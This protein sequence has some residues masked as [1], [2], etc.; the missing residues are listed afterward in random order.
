MTGLTGESL[1]L[2]S[3]SETLCI[4]PRRAFI[5]IICLAYVLL[6]V[7]PSK[8]EAHQLVLACQEHCQ[9][10]NLHKEWVYSQY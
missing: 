9:H 10:D 7:S 5:T 3:I 2:H 1:R 8:K 4:W 6:D